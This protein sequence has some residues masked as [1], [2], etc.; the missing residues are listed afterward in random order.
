[1]TRPDWLTK[2]RERDHALLKKNLLQIV[3]QGIYPA[4][5]NVKLLKFIMEEEKMM[6]QL[7]F[8]TIRK[9]ARSVQEQEKS[10]VRAVIKYNYHDKG[11]VVYFK[12]GGK[13]FKMLDGF[14]IKVLSCKWDSSFSQMTSHWSKKDAYIKVFTDEQV[15]LDGKPLVI[16]MD[17]FTLTEETK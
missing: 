12:Q 1:M 14:N 5:Y 13:F 15:L 6:T 11:T 10:K 4:E 16:P 7:R 9:A 17:T 3:S 2:Y 8:K